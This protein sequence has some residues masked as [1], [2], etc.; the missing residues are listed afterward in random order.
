MRVTPVPGRRHAGAETP[1]LHDT[2]RRRSAIRLSPLSS[3]KQRSK[4]LQS[5]QTGVRAHHEAVVLA[6]HAIEESLPA[7]IPGV[8]GGERTEMARQQPRQFGAVAQAEIFPQM[9]RLHRTPRNHRGKPAA[10][11]ALAR[12]LR[13]QEIAHHRDLVILGT[14]HPRRATRTPMP[15]AAGNHCAIRL[16]RS[17]AASPA[18]SATAPSLHGGHRQ[19]RR[20]HMP[21]EAQIVVDGGVGRVDSRSATDRPRRRYARCP[22]PR[23]TRQRL[24]RRDC[25]DQLLRWCRC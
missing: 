1:R 16:A 7:H 5:V 17:S 24:Q 22:A 4:S 3:P 9:V 13:E 19:D 25:V 20:Q 8:A 10:G 15:Q 6:E 14:L 18:R 2:S 12:A 11:V 23:R 21:V